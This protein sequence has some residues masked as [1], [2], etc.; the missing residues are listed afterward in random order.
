MTAQVS[1]ALIV[2]YDNDDVWFIHVHVRKDLSYSMKRF[3]LPLRQRGVKTENSRAALYFLAAR[4]V[5]SGRTRPETPGTRPH[6]IP[7]CLQRSFARD[8]TTLRQASRFPLPWHVVFPSSMAALRLT[9]PR[10][11]RKGRYS[12]RFLLARGLYPPSSRGGC[13]PPSS[14]GGC[15][16]VRLLLCGVAPRRRTSVR[17]SVIRGSDRKNSIAVPEASSGK[18]PPPRAG[19][20]PP[21]LARGLYPRASSSSRGCTPQTDVRASPC[22]PRF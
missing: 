17:L 22:N 7:S 11:S 20:V 16:P 12:I 13:T 15:T 6:A 19:V 14:R 5:V 3:L 2:R 18:T 21:L 10:L 8:E 9:M 1:I 4:F